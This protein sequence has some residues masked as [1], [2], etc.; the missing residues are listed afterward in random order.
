MKRNRL[1]FQPSNDNIIFLPQVYT[2]FHF[3]TCSHSNVKSLLVVASLTLGSRQGQGH[4]V[5]VYTAV[6]DLT[7]K[8]SMGMFAGKREIFFIHV[9][10]LFQSTNVVTHKFIF[11]KTWLLYCHT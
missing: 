4:A 7:L 1:Q 3:G 2:Q 11:L 9:F 10:F 5:C 8:Y 6:P